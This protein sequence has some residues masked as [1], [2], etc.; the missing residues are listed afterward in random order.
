MAP[1]P[2]YAQIQ[3]NVIE[4]A[5]E[6]K[7]KKFLFLSSSCAYPKDYEKQPLKEEYMLEGPLEETNAGYALAKICGSKLCEY[8]NKKFDTK[9]ITLASSNVY[10]PGD[11]FNLESSHAL[12]AMILKTYNAIKNESHEIEM[13]GNGLARREW[14][15]VDDLC[16]A[17]IW[18][19]KNLTH[20]DTFLNVGTGI[21]IDMNSLA[22]KI[23]HQMGQKIVIKHNLSKPNGMLVKR[24]DVTKINELGWKAKV[25]LDDGIIN[26]V[27]WFLRNVVND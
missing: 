17:I 23:M 18:S 25:D 24:L 3:N 19:M 20:T 12:A 13:W 22:T 9:F 4:A 27:E 11:H 1:L 2:A 10:G 14:L 6:S 7:V 26:T 8:A 21:D 5:I 15:Y 16:D